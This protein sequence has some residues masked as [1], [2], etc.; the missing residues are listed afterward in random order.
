MP[1]SIDTHAA[2]LVLLLFHIYSEAGTTWNVIC[3]SGSET[4]PISGGNGTKVSLPPPV[5]LAMV[6][7][8]RL[9]YLEESQYSSGKEAGLVNKYYCW[10]LLF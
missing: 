4:P 6:A 3:S 10:W 5:P 9:P 7:S 2:W 1:H 8:H